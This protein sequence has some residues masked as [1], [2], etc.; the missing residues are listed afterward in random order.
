MKDFIKEIKGEL[1][2]NKI[3]DI[4]CH[5]FYDG[6]IISSQGTI[7]CCNQN[8]TDIFGYKEEE[9]EGIKIS[10]LFPNIPVTE[11]RKWFERE[12]AIIN[13][14]KK[15]GTDCIVRIRG[16]VISYKGSNLQ[17]FAIQDLTETENYRQIIRESEERYRVLTESLLDGVLL[18]DTE[19]NIVY[20]NPGAM[21]MFGFKDIK[22]IQKK[23]FF[24]LVLPRFIKRVKTDFKL[25]SSGK[26]EFLVEYQVMD[27]KGTSFWVETIGNRTVFGGKESNLICLRDITERKLAEESLKKMQGRMKKVLEETVSALSRTIAEKDPYTSEHQRRVSKLACTIAE[28]MGLPSDFI[29]GLRIASILHDIGKIYIPGEILSAPRALTEIESALIH[30]HPVKGYNILKDIDFPWPVAKI[31]LEHHERLDGSGYPNKISDDDILLEARI[32]AVADVV[33]AI[34]SHR[35]YREPLGIQLA[36]EEIELKKGLLYDQKAVDACKDIF[37][38]GFRL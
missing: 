21:E 35:P 13:G 12:G 23:S 6:F 11:K 4:I 22:D 18:T 20:A 32:L 14:R 33:E 34:G 5:T 38:M 17:F 26:G 27:V 1:R 8:L 2:K 3:V 29:D 19:G 25:I 7:I 24:D 36:L 10:I 37:K 15:D 30:L 31:V 16:K 28:K 9:L